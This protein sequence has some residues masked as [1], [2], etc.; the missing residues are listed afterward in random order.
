MPLRNQK[1]TNM[2]TRGLG[3]KDFFFLFVCES[4]WKS[5]CKHVTLFMLLYAG[6][7]GFDYTVNAM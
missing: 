4:F 5:F 7:C 2:I 6:F 3:K 1:H